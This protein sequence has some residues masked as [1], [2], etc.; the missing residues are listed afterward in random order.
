MKPTT[1]MNILL[2]QKMALFYI[3]LLVRNRIP[4]IAG[5]SSLAGEQ[6]HGYCWEQDCVSSEDVAM[7]NKGAG[8]EDSNGYTQ[9]S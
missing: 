5:R 6:V 9:L 1:T 2:G 3:R 8:S 7:H 4:Y